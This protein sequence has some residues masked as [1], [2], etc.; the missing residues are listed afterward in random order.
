[1]TNY[2]NFIGRAF[3]VV[4]DTTNSRTTKDDLF[5]NVKEYF[6]LSEARLM[7]FCSRTPIKAMALQLSDE[8]IE[9]LKE[10]ITSPDL[11]WEERKENGRCILVFK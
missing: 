10:F 1:M 11:N 4:I 3:N 7:V 6:A 5:I 8:R 2:D 9:K